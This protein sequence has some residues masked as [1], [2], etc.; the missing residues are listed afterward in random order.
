MPQGSLTFAVQLIS[1]MPRET[2]AIQGTSHIWKAGRIAM[3]V[4]DMPASVPSIA[5]RG[6][7]LPNGR[8][9]K[10]ADQHDHADDEG[11]GEACLPGKH[12]SGSLAH[13]PEFLR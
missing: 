9:D 3:N 6:V 1:T 4:I 11:P 7:N 10:G 8:T 13:G 5:A 12:G 2:K